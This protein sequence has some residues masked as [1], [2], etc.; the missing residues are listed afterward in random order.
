MCRATSEQ[1]NEK[2]IS[3]R[4]VR[5]ENYGSSD[6]NEEGEVEAGECLEVVKSVFAINVGLTSDKFM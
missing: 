3:F 4:N 2:Q 1:K 5:E 6:R